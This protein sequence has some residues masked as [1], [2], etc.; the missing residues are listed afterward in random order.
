MAIATDSRITWSELTTSVLNSIKSVCCNID[1]F[2]ANVPNNLRYGTASDI[3]VW[4]YTTSGSGH[5]FAAQ[6]YIFI[7]KYNIN[8]IS[9]VPTSTVNSEWSSFLTA[10]GINAHSNKLI[11]ANEFGLAIGLCS[12]FMSYH[13]KRVYSKRQLISGLTQRDSTWYS[14]DGVLFQG[15]KYVS[16]IIGGVALSPKYTLSGIQPSLPVPVVT[17]ANITSTVRQNIIHDGTNYGILDRESQ[18]VL[19]RVYIYK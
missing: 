2:A 11:Q 15:T 14:G 1:T 4:D 5:L 3:N 9:T 8:L 10:A 19:H 12:Q 16:G 18:P 17:D 6:R 13:L 7:S